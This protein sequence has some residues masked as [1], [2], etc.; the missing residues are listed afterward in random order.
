MRTRFARFGLR[1]V[2]I[3][4]VVISSVLASYRL[5]FEHGRE[6]GPII[7]SDLDPQRIY[8]REYDVSDII[9]SEADAQLVIDS[10]SKVVEPDSWAVV[11]GY[12]EI[13]FNPDTERFTVSHVWLGH[14]LVVNYLNDVREAAAWRVNTNI[15]RDLA[16][17]VDEAQAAFQGSIGAK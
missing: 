8:D 3:A 15:P 7:P 1:A 10:L 13:S 2:F 14:A 12:A 6:F 5:G 4:I 11:G 17:T 16:I 9:H